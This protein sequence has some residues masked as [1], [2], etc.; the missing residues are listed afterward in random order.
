MDK[1]GTRMSSP[2]LALSRRL[3]VHTITVEGNEFP[4]APTSF[5]VRNL[6]CWPVEEPSPYEFICGKHT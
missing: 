5:W 4:G 1:M 2:V 3:C 6:I